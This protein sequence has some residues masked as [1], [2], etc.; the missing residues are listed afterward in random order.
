VLDVSHCE[1]IQAHAA[2]RGQVETAADA[3]AVAAAVVPFAALGPVVGDRAAG[4][5]DRRS[6]GEIDAASEAVA[7]ATAVLAVAAN[8]PVVVERAIDSLLHSS[9]SCAFTSTSAKS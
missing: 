3:L 5:A 6:A 4:D 7:T 1:G 8:G 9:S 2:A